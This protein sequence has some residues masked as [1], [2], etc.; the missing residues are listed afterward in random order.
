[1]KEI[2]V[3]RNSSGP[4]K[5]LVLIFLIIVTGRSWAIW[6][7]VR[8]MLLAAVF[9]IAYVAVERYS[10]MKLSVTAEKVHVVNFNSRYSLDLD[11]VRID[12]EKN[13]GAWPQDDIVR[14]KDGTMRNQMS[15]AEPDADL[16][17]ND[18]VEDNV[19]DL[20]DALAANAEKSNGEEVFEEDL[21]ED[22]EMPDEVAPPSNVR[23]IKK[24]R[25]LILTDES[26]VKAQ[27]GVAPSY[28]A[29]LDEIAEE[30]YIAID[31]M[32]AVGG[33]AS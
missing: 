24:A 21:M 22:L 9:S 13:H 7:P 19:L 1:M 10:R 31:R 2:V 18:E 11:S 25:L 27:V 8:F 33:K 16:A 6:W 17:A 3:A 5:V 15:D 32:R 20:S 30:L 14:F 26:G 28:G 29:R 23:Q 12:D 4:L